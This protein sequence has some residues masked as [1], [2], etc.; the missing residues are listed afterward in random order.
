MG[1]LTVLTSDLTSDLT[2][3]LILDGWTLLAR[4]EGGCFTGTAGRPFQVPLNRLALRR[5][6]SSASVRAKDR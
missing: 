3:V 4:G 1:P 6:A 2:S 5:S